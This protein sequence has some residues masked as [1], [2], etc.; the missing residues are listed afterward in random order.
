MPVIIDPADYGRWLDAAGNAADLLPLLETWPVKGM[1][2]T[3][4]NPVLNNPRHE[5]PDC[6]LAP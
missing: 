6:V 4:A 2:V 1:E 5:G 3:A